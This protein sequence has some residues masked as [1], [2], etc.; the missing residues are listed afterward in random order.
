MHCKLCRFQLINSLN[1][2]GAFFL[3]Y[4]FLMVCGKAT[5]VYGGRSR[6]REAQCAEET[7]STVDF[8][9][10]ILGIHSKYLELTVMPFTYSV[11]SCFLANRY[12]C[13]WQNNNHFGSLFLFRPL[14]FWWKQIARK[15]KQWSLHYCLANSVSSTIVILKTWALCRLLSTPT[16]LSWVSRFF[17]FSHGLRQDSQSHGFCGKIILKWNVAL[18]N[19]KQP[20]TSVKRFQH[21]TKR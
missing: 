8:I 20:G 10:D 7:L 11:S 6:D 13:K 16:I 19:K 3:S 9:P 18:L 14:I 17:I 5:S 2:G 15:I 12:V 1:A 4:K 21:L